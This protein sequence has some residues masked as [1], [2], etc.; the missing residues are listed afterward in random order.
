MIVV[1]GLICSCY[2]HFTDQQ[3]GQL[4]ELMTEIR[5]TEL[6]KDDP[7]FVPDPPEKK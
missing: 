6:E 3:I 5:K 1:T 4:Y 7:D 2:V